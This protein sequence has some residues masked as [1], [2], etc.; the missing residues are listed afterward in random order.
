VQRS[1]HFHAFAA[2]G[3][4]AAEITADPLPL[5]PHIRA[6]P[7][8]RV[9]DLNGQVLLLGVGHDANT[10]LHLA[11]LIAEVPYR[12]PS[13]CTVLENGRAVQLH[14]GENNH[15]C[16]RFALADEWLRARGL[17]SEGRVGHAQARLA[18]SRDIVSVALEQLAKDPLLFLHQPEE[19]CEECLEARQSVL[20]AERMRN[21]G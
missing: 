14:Y 18:D 21:M 9:H 12:T 19:G 7:V 8:G 13:Y 4:H 2:I 15:C 3:R 11:E 20:A 5:P 10:T 16:L 1:D 17:Q 6:S